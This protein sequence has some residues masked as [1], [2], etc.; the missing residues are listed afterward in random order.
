M[1]EPETKASLKKETLLPGWWTPLP[2]EK[3][4]INQIGLPVGLR[5]LK[6]NWDGYGAN[7]IPA[8]PLKTA[9][10]VAL[11]P[12]GDGTLQFEFTDGMGGE[13]LVSIGRDGRIT[14]VHAE[15]I[16]HVETRGCTILPSEPKVSGSSP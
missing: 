6:K 15:N 16:A 7:P 14:W 11:V 5:D 3:R 10:F 13:V 8:E 2:D 4:W 12:G 1:E 9:A